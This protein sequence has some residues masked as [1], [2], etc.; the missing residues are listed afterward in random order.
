MINLD[1]YDHQILAILQNDCSVS[2]DQL[3]NQVHLS[4]NACWRRVKQLETSGVIRKRVAL[5]DPQNVGCPQMVFVLIRTSS[6]EPGWMARFNRTVQSLPE[7]VG[8]HRLTGELDYILTVRVADVAAYDQ[9]YKR[10][11]AKVPV[12]DI[13]ASFVMESMKDTTAL[14][15]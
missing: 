11:I 2:A 5:L 12:S 7:I 10:L 4:R 1:T 15:L 8:A 6:H 14:P 3:A 9:F 13:S